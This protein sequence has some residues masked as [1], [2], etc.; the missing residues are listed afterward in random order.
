MT[1]DSLKYTS[2][3]LLCH[4]CIIFSNAPNS[5]HFVSTFG[6]Q[7]TVAK[8]DAMLKYSYQCAYFLI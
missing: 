7:T 4:V 6:L 2:P 1:Q 8:G 3:E 5:T